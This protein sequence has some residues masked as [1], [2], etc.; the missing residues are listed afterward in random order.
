[1]VKKLPQ[2]LYLLDVS[3]AVDAL[4]KATKAELNSVEQWLNWQLSQVPERFFASQAFALAVTRMQ[5]NPQTIQRLSAKA[6]KIDLSY[7]LAQLD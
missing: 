2:S 5:N 6:V 3:Q 1:M 4:L 7:F